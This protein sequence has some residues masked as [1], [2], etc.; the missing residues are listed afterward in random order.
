L[1]SQFANLAARNELS[2]VD[3]TTVLTTSVVRTVA[4]HSNSQ[5]LT[6]LHPR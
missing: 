3:L 2:N 4:P 5:G 1:T 6:T